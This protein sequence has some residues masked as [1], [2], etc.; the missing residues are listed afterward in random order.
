MIL[1]KENIFLI[2]RS[3]NKIF[4][5]FIANYAGSSSDDFKEQIAYQ[6]AYV[7]WEHVYN[8]SSLTQEQA[9]YNVDLDAVI[10]NINTLE[11]EVSKLRN[12]LISLGKKNFGSDFEVNYLRDISI[13][14]KSS[15]FK[16]MR[17]EK[18]NASYLLKE[19]TVI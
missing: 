16:L 9:I 17:K 14:L 19:V 8:N 12:K 7:A 2:L 5:N 11:K 1:T 10:N 3:H 6:I 18:I 4:D 15:I 13:C